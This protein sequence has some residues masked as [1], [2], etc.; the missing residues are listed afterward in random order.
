MSSGEDACP[1]HDERTR[2]NHFQYCFSAKHHRRD[3]RDDAQWADD[4]SNVEEFGVFD[5]ADFHER[6]DT[7]GN[8]YG[9]RR[10]PE[11]IL[12]TLG[13]R[14]QHI[15]EFPQPSNPEEHPWHGYPLWPLFRKAGEKTNRRGEDMRPPKAVLQ[16]M[17]A[18]G[19]L[20]AIQRRRLSKGEHIR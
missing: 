20:T 7:Q 1:A 10:S 11:G 16:R 8:L 4:L 19:L 12:L 17:E 2:R 5:L 3:D 14:H 9:L 6:T 13:T 15:A 18:E